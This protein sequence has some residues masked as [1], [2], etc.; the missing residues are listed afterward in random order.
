MHIEVLV[1]DN[2]G[3]KL[4]DILLPQLLGL[5]GQPHT[6]RLISYK[7]LAAFPRV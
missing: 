3:R 4:L 2:S 6:W 1:E 7:A 5:Y